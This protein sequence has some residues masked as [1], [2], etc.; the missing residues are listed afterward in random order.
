MDAETIDRLIIAAKAAMQNAHAPYSEFPVGAALLL[1][2]GQ[3]VTGC[4][5]ENASFGGT[6]CAERTAISAAVAMGRSDFDAICV[7]ATTE[8]AITPCGI[9]RQTIIEFSRDLQVICCNR[10]GEH[11]I[12]SIADLLPHAFTPDVL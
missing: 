4:N 3:I 12:Y 2:D 5:V 1:S 7:I 11:Q 8:N 10:D 6:V 9:C